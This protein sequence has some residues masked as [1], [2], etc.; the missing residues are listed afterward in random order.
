ML[1]VWPSTSA[2]QQ[3]V[4]R[5]TSD[6]VPVFVT[7]TDK[8]GRLVTNLT[9]EDFQVFDNGKPQ[10]ITMFDN[11]PQPIR[12]IALIDL[13]GSMGLNLPLIRA[14]VTELVAHLGPNDL[15]RVGTFGVEVKFS[16]A[17]TTN[18]DEL[19]AMLPAD[20]PRNAPTPLWQ[21]A[22]QAITEFG[23]ASGGRRVVLVLS[24][25]KDSPDLTKLKRFITAPEIEDRA[26]REDVMVY[27]VGLRSSPGP[28]APGGIQSLGAVLADT[29]PD[30]A[31]GTVAINTGGGYFE[32][33]GRDNVS[34]AFAR[35][36]DELH[37]QYLIGFAP[38]ARDG[39]THKLEV[40]LRDKSLKPQTRKNYLAP[41]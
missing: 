15:A 3:Q 8:A 25:G 20:I 17:F 4:F 36:V 40:K 39:K 2:P 38:P 16:P 30:P 12:L 24:D 37:S 6:V 41:K 35:V 34:A 5:S 32:L 18:A 22:D 21:S 9:R 14:A 26:Q 7:V 33:R 29:L 10:P 19:L 31:L 11:S 1:L 28:I 27:G 13:S 23:G